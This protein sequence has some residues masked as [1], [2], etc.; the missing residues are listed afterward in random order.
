MSRALTL[1][2]VATSEEEPVEP[3]S[4]SHLGKIYEDGNQR[5]LKPSLSA[6]KPTYQAAQ[7]G[8]IV[9]PPER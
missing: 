2:S 8:S 5:Y 3:T 6:R 7:K 9:E 1:Q 4:E